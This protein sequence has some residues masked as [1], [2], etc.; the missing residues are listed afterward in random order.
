M[1]VFKMTTAIILVIIL[2]LAAIIF[3]LL[4]LRKGDQNYSNS[5]RRNTTNLT[6]IYVIA[7][8]LSLIAL[9]IYIRIF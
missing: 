2:T 9:A 1:K 6:V 8:F 3:T 7:I 5:A 4:F